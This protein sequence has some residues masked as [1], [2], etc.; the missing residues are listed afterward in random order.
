MFFSD[1]WLVAALMAVP[2]EHKYI[3][4]DNRHFQALA[5]EPFLAQVSFLPTHFSNVT[6]MFL[7]WV[8]IEN[9]RWN[10]MKP[11]MDDMLSREYL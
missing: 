5:P 2:T 7:V 10:T 8:L 11:Q 3:C 4:L 1:V 9:Q 6:I